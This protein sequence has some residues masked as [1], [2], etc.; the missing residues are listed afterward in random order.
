M[1]EE[2]SEAAAAPRGDGTFPGAGELSRFLDHL[3]ARNASPGTIEEYR[4]HAGEFLAFLRQRG[5]DWRRPDRVTIRAYLASLADRDLAAASVAGRLAAAR[6]FYRHAVRQG[7]LETNPLTGVRSPRKPR[8][9]PRVLSPEDAARLVEAPT[10]AP[11]RT[12]RGVDEA[13]ADALA[14]RDAA[15]LE[16]LYAT[17]MRI[18]EAASLSLDRLDLERRRLRVV[19]KGSRERELVFGRPAQA[20]LAAYLRSGRPALAARARATTPGVFLNAAGGPLTA[21]GARLIVERWVEAAA[22]ATKTSPH[23][24]RHSF[25]THLLEG[26]ADLR[27]VQELLGHANLA[28]T[29]VYTHLSDAALRGAYRAAHPRAG[30]AGRGGRDA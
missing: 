23:T 2:R 25:A 24:L 3:R 20:A 22:V 30:G 14:R 21:R 16:L 28:T 26:G 5:V 11:R 9:L 13:L 12:R 29:Q 1:P 4:R 6:S 10:R 19:G 18:S 15:L 8:R 27:S 7:W 17:G